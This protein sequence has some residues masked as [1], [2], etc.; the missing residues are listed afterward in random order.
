MVS[1]KYNVLKR[2]S[3]TVS[4]HQVGQC[5]TDGVQNKH[6][7]TQPCELSAVRSSQVQPQM[8]VLSDSVASRLACTYQ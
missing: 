1:Q 5:R 6:V 4:N 7:V 3:R 8:R 2:C